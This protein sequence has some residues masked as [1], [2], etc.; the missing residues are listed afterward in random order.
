MLLLQELLTTLEFLYFRLAAPLHPLAARGGNPMRIL[1]TLPLLAL[2][3]AANRAEAQEQPQH[4]FGLGLQ[5]GAPTAVVGKYYIGGSMAFAMG[6]GFVEQWRDD[7]AFHLHFDVLWHPVVLARTADFTLPVYLG[8]GGRYKHDD[9]DHCYWNGN[10]RVC[11]YEYDDD[12]HIGIRGP[13]GLLMDFN[14][15]PLDIF[16][17]LA[18]VVDIIEL[19]SDDDPY[20]DDDRVNLYGAIGARYYF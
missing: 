14:R 13:V 2:L 4:P 6:V 8:V 15:I 16:L 10:Q 19:D 1:K 18:L 7:D 17:E 11:Y 12:D 3:L 9:D 5:L 20:D